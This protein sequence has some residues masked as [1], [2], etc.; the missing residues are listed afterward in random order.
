MSHAPYDTEAGPFRGRKYF[1]VTLGCFR[2]EVE[3][4]MLR[5]SLAGLGLAEGK[6]VEA[7]DLIIVNTCGFLAEA[8]DEGIDTILEL[9]SIASRT[10]NPPPIVVLG[11]M[12]QRY[13]A[14]LALEMPEVAA[15]LGTDWAHGLEDALTAVLKGAR[16]IGVSKKARPS[17]ILRTENTGE[18]ATLYVRIADGCDR[19]CR[20]C[21]IPSIRGPFR[22]RHPEDI[23][24]E[25]SRLSGGREREVI[26]LAQDATDYGKDLPGKPGL[27]ELVRMVSE[28]EESRWVRLLYLQP[29]GLTDELIGEIASNVRVCGYFDVP[30]QHASESVLRR[31]GRPGGA[32]EH[33][34]LISRIRNVA[35]EAAIRTTVMVGYPGESDGEFDELLRFIEEVR[36]D[37][38]G[39]FIFSPEEGTASEMLEDRVP[40]ELATIRYDRI[41]EAQDAVEE[42]AVTRFIGKEIEV[43]VDGASE[44]EEYD[45]VGRSYR[46]APVVDG[47]VYIRDA[48]SL[49][50]PGEFVTVTV[51]GQEGLDLVADT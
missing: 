27:H 36:F 42:A 6:T 41:V 44:L 20:F 31:M 23:C 3:S 9:H 22:S 1:L 33:G 34:E 29:E 11:C 30:F 15:V 40:P 25:I 38:V 49:A 46:E 18:G 28:V 14:S 47:V 12:G 37:W 4:D 39:A 16:Y 26:L 13:G 21:A 43:V 8:C 51:T 19:A 17:G 2:N 35:G 7:A 10:Q 48:Q 24:E 50:A 45:L 5:S 32:A